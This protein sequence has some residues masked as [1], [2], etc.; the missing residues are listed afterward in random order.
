[1]YNFS[2]IVYTLA[3]NVHSVNLQSGATDEFQ[4]IFVPYCNVEI[5]E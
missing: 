1:M 5:L 4:Y 3:K 2:A